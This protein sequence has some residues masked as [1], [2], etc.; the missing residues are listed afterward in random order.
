MKLVVGLGNPG[1]KYE[2]TRH[3]IGFLCADYLV[4]CWKAVGPDTKHQA[5]VWKATVAG[6]QVMLIQPQTFMNLSGRSVASFYQF[7]KCRPEDVIVIYDELDLA[8]NDLRFKTGGGSG[9]HNGIKSIDEC[10]GA[11]QL[12]YH[13]VRLGIG[14]PRNYN[15]NIDVAD[16]VLGKI[17]D[18]QWGQLEDL[19]KVAA[20]GIELILQ[21]KMKEAMNQYHGK[22]PGGL[23]AAKKPD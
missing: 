20:S 2:T 15:S 11:G 23:A 5:R 22:A 9:G 6:E 13:R 8:P 3:N 16:W 14:H 21:G 4:D 18:P 17:Q 19:F 1:P 10:L 7:Y 12:N